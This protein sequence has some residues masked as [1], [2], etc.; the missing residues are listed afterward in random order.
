M[1]AH[2]LFEWTNAAVSAVGLLLTVAAVIQA[3][4]AKKAAV[5]AREAIWRREASFVVI[6]LTSLS[7]ELAGHI[8]GD[9]FQAAQTRARDLSSRIARDQARFRRFFSKDFRLLVDLE[10]QFSEI[11]ERLS[12]PESFG[13]RDAVIDMANRV[14]EAN[15]ILNGICGRQ[16]SG[17]DEE[18]S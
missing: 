15:R 2:D 3:T 9:R 1:N 7:L 17:F 11:A 10:K 4:G 6:E 18:G 14:H 5:D 16:E 8:E 13:T 12:R